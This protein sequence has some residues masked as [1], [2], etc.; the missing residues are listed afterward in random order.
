MLEVAAGWLLAQARQ[1]ADDRAWSRLTGLLVGSK[2]EG[3]LT[4][5]TRDAL[6]ATVVA[7][8]GEGAS[9]SDVE[10]VCDVLDQLWPSIDVAS[11]G[12][13]TLLERVEAITREAM[14]IATRPVDL[15][16]E[17]EPTSSLAAFEHEVHIELDPA[18]FAGEFGRRWVQAVR[19]RAVTET[20]LAELGNQLAH[21]QTHRALMHAEHS[22]R[23]A[24]RV[25]ASAVGLSVSRDQDDARLWVTNRGTHRVEAIEVNA[26]PA[27]DDWHR[28]THGPLPELELDPPRGVE[29]VHP[30]LG[31]WFYA[32]VERLSPGRGLMIAAF[33]LDVANYDAIDF[34]LSWIDHAGLQRKSHA[35]AELGR[36]DG[37]IAM[38][39]RAPRG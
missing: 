23:A 29:L 32:T 36:V 26:I 34:D 4:L 31:G 27:D 2:A 25:H 39:V 12:D 5:A 14:S 22:R 30:I 18:T 24:D 15:G 21:D 37:D 8:V 35:V 28:S 33:R 13:G 6:H 3:S 17:F 10:R 16:P 9:P 20:A 19:D 7:S 1:D 38:E 11:A